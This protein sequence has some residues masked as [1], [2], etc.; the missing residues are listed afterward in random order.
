MAFL[1]LVLQ[2]EFER[3][4]GKAAANKSFDLLITLKNAQTASGSTV[5]FT[6]IA[7]QEFQ[8]LVTFF[9]DRGLKVVALMQDKQ[10][11]GVLDQLAG[12]SSDEEDDYVTK[13]MRAQGMDVGDSDEEDED[14][15]ARREGCPRIYMSLDISVMSTH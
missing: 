12:L 1:L 9:T 8:A 6:N 2:L 11:Q 14:F 15:K 10:R 3:Q 7:Q 13:Q 5:R 4:S